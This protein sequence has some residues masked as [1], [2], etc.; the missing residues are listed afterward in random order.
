MCR[1]IVL[2]NFASCSLVRQLAVDQQVRDF[3]KVALRR[4][5]LDAVAAIAENAAVA[6]EKRDAAGGR[7]GVGVALVERRAAGGR[8]QLGDVEPAFLLGA[9]DDGQLKILAIQLQAG[10]VS[11]R[12]FLLQHRAHERDAFQRL[13]RGIR[14]KNR[15]QPEV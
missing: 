13:E 10:G 5:V 9:D 15:A 4:Q 14:C 11:G 2:R 1:R 8:E 3:Q 7:A 6:V 12:R